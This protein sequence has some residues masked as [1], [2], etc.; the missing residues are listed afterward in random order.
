MATGKSAACLL[1]V[2]AGAVFS[3]S[4]AEAQVAFARV[5][6]PFQNGVNLD[7]T[8]VVSH[9]RRYVRMSLNFQST[10]LEGFDRYS[11]PAAVGGTGNGGGF[12][13]GAGGGGA[14]GGGGRGVGA[15][16]GEPSGKSPWG[17]GQAPVAI[18]K[19]PGISLDFP[20]ELPPTPPAQAA[21]ARKP[22]EP[23]IAR[24]SSKR[25]TR[26]KSNFRRD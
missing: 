12:G 1:I 21:S 15:L 11:V 9:D 24:G 7:V 26:S 18:A 20:G 3:S 23:V 10:A 2:L 6:Q 13:G 4:S 14:N 16:F 5:V 22:K 25:R 19:G 17:N 8:P